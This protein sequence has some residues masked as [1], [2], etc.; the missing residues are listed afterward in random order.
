MPTVLV[1]TE[2][3]TGL[4]K[5]EQ[6]GSVELPF[7]LFFLAPRLRL[8]LRVRQED[9]KLDGFIHGGDSGGS[10]TLSLV[11]W[12]FPTLP[13]FSSRKLATRPANTAIGSPQLMRLYAKI[14]IT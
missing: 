6:L 3:S 4:P 9:S 8:D 7:L 10:A 13:V 1:T 11:L 5:S 2:S 14:D 12:T